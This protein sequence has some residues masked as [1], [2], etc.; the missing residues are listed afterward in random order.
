MTTINYLANL[1]AEIL[2]NIFSHLKGADLIK[3]TRVN[4]T[5]NKI[6]GNSQMD[7]ICIKSNDSSRQNLFEIRDIFQYTDREYKNIRMFSVK[8]VNFESF[9]TY[10]F[11][12]KSV[13]LAHSS[14]SSYE[15]LKEFILKFV[16]TLVELDLEH[17]TFPS[18]FD[19]TP[20]VL[21]KLKV[22]RCAH[23]RFEAD[24][25]KMLEC[26][27]GNLREFAVTYRSFHDDN[28]PIMY[29]TNKLEVLRVSG[30]PQAEAT[31]PNLNQFLLLQKD[32]LREIQVD[33]M[34]KLT[35]QLIW[36]EL[37]CYKVV[38]NG[39]CD[40]LINNSN[41]IL[42]R[43]TYIQTIFMS[44][45]MQYSLLDKIVHASPNLKHISTP[46]FRSKIIHI[47]VDKLTKLQELYSYKTENGNVR[48]AVTFKVHES[49]IDISTE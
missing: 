12:W 8:A 40:L 37:K 10:G 7:K 11:K 17:L 14:I 23:F 13:K 1:P 43:N 45:F 2:I 39:N 28:I 36:N 42:Q 3:L 46:S 48:R 33:A 25:L 26:N 4:K 30:T 44:R 24:I 34:S 22:L 35:L 19:K 47:V 18:R 27:I 31:T 21:P 29:L 32:H 16:N 6:I 9:Q 20:I 38:T 41:F 15:V 5:W 49:T